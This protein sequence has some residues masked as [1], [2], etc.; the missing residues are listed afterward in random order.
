MSGHAS[1]Y[2]ISNRVKFFCFVVEESV[3]YIFTHL[4]LAETGNPTSVAFSSTDSGQMIASYTSSECVCFDLETA[5]IS[6]RL[7]SAKTYSECLLIHIS[8]HFIF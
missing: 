6:L 3:R 2:F 8:L 5:K 7:D 1:N 4:F